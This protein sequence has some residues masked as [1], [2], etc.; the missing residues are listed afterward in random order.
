MAHVI[1]KPNP[2]YIYGMGLVVCAYSSCFFVYHDQ[3]ALPF[4][5]ACT[6]QYVDESVWHSP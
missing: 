4:V 2:Q 5:S 1:A 3:Q 6:L